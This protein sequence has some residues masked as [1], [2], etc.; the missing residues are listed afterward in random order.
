M[1]KKL[2]PCF[3][4]DNVK[5]KWFYENAGDYV[6]VANDKLPD[7]IAVGYTLFNFFCSG[8]QLSVSSQDLSLGCFF[9]GWVVQKYYSAPSFELFQ[10]I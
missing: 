5:K 8:N 4:E 9:L 2:C 10:A 3:Q 1:L 6:K 7:K